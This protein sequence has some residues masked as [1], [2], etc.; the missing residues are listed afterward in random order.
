[1]TF[2]AEVL[3]LETALSD[4]LSDLIKLLNQDF[5]AK[6]GEEI[7]YFKDKNNEPFILINLN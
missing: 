1:M 6:K 4:F 7:H 3:I 2:W 5:T